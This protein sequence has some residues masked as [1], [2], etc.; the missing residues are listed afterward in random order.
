M[1]KQQARLLTRIA[2]VVDA[3]MIVT[4]FVAAYLIMEDYTHLA[5]WGQYDWFLI[6]MVPVL[7][8][9]MGHFNLYATLRT[10]K[11][12]DIFLGLL[13]VHAI[14][15]VILSSSI[16]LIDPRGFSRLL[17][18]A[19]ILLSFALIFTAKVVIKLVLFNLRR[20]GYNVRYLLLAGC[21]ESSAE[22]I[23]LIREHSEWGLV[24]SG[25]AEDQPYDEETYCGVPIIGRTVDLLAFCRNNP[26]DE[27]IWCL[28]HGTEEQEDIFY[29]VLKMGITFRSVLDYSIRPTTRTDLSL[30]HGQFQIL[31][32]Y[33]KEFNSSQLLAKRSLD[34]AGAIVGL[35][36]TAVLFPFIALAIRLDSPG[37]IVFGQMRL[38][39]NGRTFKCW[40]FRSM[41]IDAEERKKDLMARNEMNGAMF[42]IADDPRVTGV[43]NFI[44]KASIDELLQFWN[45]LK[46]DMSL[47]GTRPPTPDEVN[48]YK[49]WHRKRICI[50]PGITG[51]W[52]VSGRN[53]INDFDEVAD[54]DIYYIDKWS[55][56]M[57]VRI[58][59]KTVWVVI[60]RSGAS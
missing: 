46:G 25:V 1:L 53:Q 8:L 9:L 13:K 14:G 34:V 47:V 18:G 23:K 56:W 24:I 39:E 36:I 32:F 2:I 20:H 31:T 60:A 33:S 41:Y 45:V 50:K 35:L 59:F 5:G 30:F 57:D 49:H 17:F 11:F 42:K 4:A 38:G 52:Q 40:K 27:V 48:T 54:L 19:S 44:R 7:L 28:E 22:L 3:V 43:G 37:P 15:T 26:V 6:L 10:R 16:F 12:V 58:L 29:H 21:S 55:F 51:L